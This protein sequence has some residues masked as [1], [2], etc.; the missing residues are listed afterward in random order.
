MPFVTY[1]KCKKLKMISEEPITL[2][3][4]GEIHLRTD[5]TIEILPDAIQ[6]IIPKRL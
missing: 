1:K 5:P 4:D 6:L 2:Q 3:A